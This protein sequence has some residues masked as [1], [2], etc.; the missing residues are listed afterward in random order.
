MRSVADLTAAARIR[1]AAL[2]RFASD[3]Y[4]GASIRAI[5]ADAG[6]SPALVLHHFGSKEGL[7]AAC[8]RHLHD[9]LQQAFDQA[10]VDGPSQAAAQL[11]DF[12]ATLGPIIHYLLR[13][14]TD[15]SEHAVALVAD[16][17]A[18]T[19]DSTSAMQEA[20]Y[21]REAP[22]PQMRAALLV[23]TRLGALLLHAAIE[24]ATGSAVTE[25]PGLDRMMAASVDL[26]QNGL[27]T[28]GALMSPPT[29][30]ASTS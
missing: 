23:C 28:D 19:A 12:A 4:A 24:R 18:M 7:R 8:D 27:F 20:G 10:A 14:A 13:Q 15:Q 25:P 6:V 9:V 21:V 16:L 22:D 26:L 29:K 5:A 11:P 17:I 30:E 2:E 1:T 3:G